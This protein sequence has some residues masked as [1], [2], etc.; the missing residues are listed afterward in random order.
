[1]ISGRKGFANFPREL[2]SS[3][4]KEQDRHRQL[5]GTT[6]YYFYHSGKQHS[7]APTAYYVLRSSI[8]AM[9]VE[10]PCVVVRSR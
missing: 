3:P 8:C 5:Y 9:I 7:G 4:E 1:M 10:S 6:T 2:Q